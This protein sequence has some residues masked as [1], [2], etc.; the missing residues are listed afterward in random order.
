MKRLLV[1][2]GALTVL[3]S[4]GCKQ[5]DPMPGKW[6]LYVAGGDQKLT[7]VSGWAEFK[8]DKS[9]EMKTKFGTQEW[10]FKGNYTVAG[11]VLTV[12]G[13]MTS[14]AK[15]YFD[16]KRQEKVPEVH[17]K[18]KLVTSGSLSEDFKTFR[19]DGK[20]FQKE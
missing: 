5:S 15:G 16:D 6:K 9:C 11:T 2:L 17:K 18:D 7:D 8:L 14:D 19:I 1:L 10:S 20:D 4:A 12:D 3:V 13:E